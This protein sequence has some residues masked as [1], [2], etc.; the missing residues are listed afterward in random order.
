VSPQA[1]IP[2]GDA[3]AVLFFVK[4]P[5]PGKV[6]TRL[7]VGL[8]PDGPQRAAALYADFACAMHATF[9][10]LPVRL[11]VQHAPEDDP[12]AVREWLGCRDCR[13]QRGTH[14]GERMANAFRDVFAAGAERAVC[15]GS[16][17][18]DLPRTIPAGALAILRRIPAVLGPAADGGYY[19]I[20]LRRDSFSDSFFTD[21]PWSTPE[22][23]AATRALLLGRLGSFGRLPVWRDVDDVE[24][25]QALSERLRKRTD[26]AWL[27]ER[28][29][30]ELS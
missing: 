29:A 28:V 2:L 20:G 3:D 10:A 22:V 5:A 25:L 14:L 11:V 6:K 15:I 13:P 1:T 24:D 4:Q 26:L 23:F 7:A 19:C 21:I 16:D 27:A 12:D 17:L 9:A 18:P 30:T 8:G